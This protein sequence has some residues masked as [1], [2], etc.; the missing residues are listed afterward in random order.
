MAFYK[1]SRRKAMR[2]LLAGAALY[3]LDSTL[4]RAGQKE[5][6]KPPPS[7]PIEGPPPLTSDELDASGKL[8]FDAVVNDQPEA[9]DA[10]FFPREPFLTLK[11][12]A[13]PARYFGELVR[14]F[15]H[16]IHSLHGKRRSWEGARFTRF[17]LGSPPRYIEPGHEWN[18][19]GYYRTFDSRLAYEIGDKTR[20]LVVHTIISWEGRWYVTHL[21]PVKH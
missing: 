15:H 4:A 5:K 3:A 14:A 9:A 16:D 17:T 21:L 1:P 11:D 19:L 12:V 7:A 2:A 6:K 20:Y 13:D 18:K 10:F 8:L